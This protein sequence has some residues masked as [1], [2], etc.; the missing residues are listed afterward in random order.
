MKKDRIR[1]ML[2]VG[3]LGL[4]GF[5]SCSPRLRPNRVVEKED[6]DTL[7]FPSDTLRFKLDPGDMPIRLMY[8]VPPVRYEVMERPDNEKTE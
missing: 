7:A 6:A 1:W 5:T 3:L 2:A 4:L 8:G